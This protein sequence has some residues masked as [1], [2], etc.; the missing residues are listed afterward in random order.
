VTGS[1]WHGVPSKAFD[2]AGIRLGTLAFSER[3][4]YRLLPFHGSNWF[5]RVLPDHAGATQLAALLVMLYEPMTHDYLPL[6]R[7]SGVAELD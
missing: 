7:V 5:G 3:M 2:Q 4:G 1:L 6:R